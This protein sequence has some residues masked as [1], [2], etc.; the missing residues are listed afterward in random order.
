MNPSIPDLADWVRRAAASEAFSSSD[1]RRSEETL[2]TLRGDIEQFIAS[3][4]DEPLEPVALTSGMRHC[5]TN[6]L[7]RWHLSTCNRP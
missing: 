1:R 7:S 3:P 6:S 2:H 4:G 5:S